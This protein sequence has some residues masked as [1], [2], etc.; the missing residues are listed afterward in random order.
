MWDR[1]KECLTE[2]QWGQS[3]RKQ[4]N[5]LMEQSYNQK[6]L[7]RMDEMQL[8]LVRFGGASFL[9]RSFSAIHTSSL[10]IMSKLRGKSYTGVAQYKKYIS[11]NQKRNTKCT[12]RQLRW[13]YTRS[14]LG[15]LGEHHR[16][17]QISANQATVTRRKP[18]SNPLEVP[19]PTSIE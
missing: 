13:M 8:I 10:Q 4:G 18:V 5:W 3:I 1:Y 14:N 2:S 9:S 12:S 19:T 7:K 15:L 6:G 17:L 16:L 11:H